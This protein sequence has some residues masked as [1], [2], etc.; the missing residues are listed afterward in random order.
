MDGEEATVASRGHANH[1]GDDP[2]DPSDTSDTSDP[3]DDLTSIDGIGRAI[4]RRLQA[5]GIRTYAD[6]AGLL[7]EEIAELL[8]GVTGIS[9]QRIAKDDWSGQAKKL[10]AR[11]PGADEQS[12][13]S[14]QHYESFVV[15]MLLDNDNDVHSTTTEHVRSGEVKRWAG[16]EPIQLANFI[17]AQAGIPPEA[18]PG[19]PA[20]EALA[21]AAPAAEAAEPGAAPGPVAI[22]GWALAL[23]PERHMLRA[24]EPFTVSLTLDPG[25]VS[26]RAHAGL[27]YM[28][29]ILAK[30]LGGG[31]RRTIGK[32][33]GTL[34]SD[35][36]AISL[37]SA[38]LPEGVY[39]LE[40]AVS[41]RE[42]AST[43]PVGLAAGKESEILQVY[44]G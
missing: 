18:D 12:P 30:P 11:S 28:A 42:A 20:P 39:R 41:L 27:Q 13:E 22:A 31:T 29:I 16:W 3:S 1:K 34:A 2:S 37:T 9:A 24:G 43:R 33:H 21:D 36:A 35:Q 6:L 4:A 8:S 26:L 5:S 40:A 10:A 14:G 25:Q 23:R 32:T 44:D 17:E 19:L 38:G 7:P 15:R